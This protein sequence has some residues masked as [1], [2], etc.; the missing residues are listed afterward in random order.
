M[1]I[2]LTFSLL[3]ITMPGIIALRLTRPAAAYTWLAAVAGA[4]LTWLS[5]LLWQFDLPWQFI[6]APWMLVEFFGE[7]PRLLANQ[8]SWMY[9][10]SLT[11]LAAAVVLTSPARSARTRPTSWLGTLVLAALGLLV[12]MVD[13][14]FALAM[15]WM[16]IDLAEF[17]A[18]IREKPSPGL[19]NRALL[20]LSLNAVGTGLVMWA[21]VAGV[22]STGQVFSLETASPQAGLFLFL[23]VVMRLAVLP[24]RLV[25]QPGESSTRRG[26]GTLMRMV[27]ATANLV[28]LSRLPSTSVEP[29][30]SVL[31]LALVGVSA[32]YAGWQ[33]ATA[34][35]ELDGRPFWL[36]GMSSLALA[37][38]LRGNPSGSVAWGAALILFGGLSFLY[39]AKQTWM[40]RG[41]ALLGLAALALP[42]T[43]TSSGW[44]GEFPLPFIFWP[45]FV[46]AHALLVGGYVRHILRPVD[47][48]LAQLPS[49]AQVAY[50][51]GMLILLVPII[52]GGLWGWPGAFNL[53]D[54]GLGIAALGLSGLAVF[55]LLRWPRLLSV[56]SNRESGWGPVWLLFIL[57]IAPRIVTFFYQLA[58]RLALYVSDLL[59]GDGGLLWT[60]LL[61]ILLMTYLRGR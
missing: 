58:G 47:V 45:L 61:L 23:A 35:D 46:L 40:T 48:D 12:V 53:G 57:G 29:T 32:L 7:S 22:A 15:A 4:L 19:T 49:W 50:P 16:A 18:V 38:F 36:I 30:W 10:L 11:A 43:L 60:I 5:V 20:S 44:Q 17:L 9:A 2:L 1:Y 39:S 24:I 59:E 6:A 37:A 14:P 34:A 54:W 28:V 56:R 13:N 21:G 52:L 55:A 42:F 51:I 33:W 25:F 41:F 31:I 27:A 26:L 8:Y 3:L